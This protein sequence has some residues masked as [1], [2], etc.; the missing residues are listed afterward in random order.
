MQ[1]FTKLS[2]NKNNPAYNTIF[3]QDNTILYETKPNAI[4]PFGIRI[5]P[6]IDSA[7]IEYNNIAQFTIPD[8]PP[9]ILQSPEIILDLT[10][11]KKENTMP[12]L[13]VQKFFEILENFPEYSCIYTDGSKCQN[14]VASAAVS[15]RRGFASRLPDNCSIFTAELTAILMALDNIQYFNKDKIMICSDSKSSL[16]AMK[17]KH[18]ENPLV[19]KILDQCSI[20]SK[21]Y[22][23]RFCWIPGHVGIKGNEKADRAAKYGL[24]GQIRRLFIPYTDTKPMIAEYIKRKLQRLWNEQEHNKLHEIFPNISK[25]MSFPKKT[26]KEQTVLTRCC[27][28][29]SRL[30]HMYLLRNEPYPE[31]VAC[32]CPMTIKHLLLECVDYAHIRTKYYHNQTIH[33]LF[34]LVDTNLILQFLREIGL[35]YQI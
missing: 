9:W 15:G 13:Y 3:R 24:N 17:N 20:L 4:K 11:Y 28:G 19:L 16:E 6:Y 7:N 26:R 30:T 5:R 33:E 1:Y 34:N 35:F 2:S 27:I 32:Q 14:K 10:Q 8:T 12:N 21:K 31:C 25:T 23:I 18:F 22:E 29:H